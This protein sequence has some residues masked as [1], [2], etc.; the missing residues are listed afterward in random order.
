VYET[1]TGRRFTPLQNLPQARASFE[2]RNSPL[3]EN[4]AVAFEFGYNVQTPD[5]LVVWEAQYGDFINGAQL[6][7]DEFVLS[8]RAKWGQ[9]PSLVL[10]L[11]HGYEGQGPDH[12]SARPERF[13]QLAADINMRVASCTTA[14][15]YFHLLRRQAALLIEDPLPLVV[16]TPK[17]L[18]RHPFMSSTPRD[19]VEGRWQRVI[20]D[21][22]V[23]GAR[24]SEDVRRLILCGGKV[25]V[26]LLTSSTRA[27]TPAV[28]ICR[29]EQ[30]YPFPVRDL[31]TVMEGYPALEEVVWVQEEPENMGAWDFVRPLLEG[32]VGS[33]RLAVLA[34]PRSSS[35]AEGSAA[36][37]AQNQERLIYKAYEVA[38]LQK[39]SLR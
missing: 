11:P 3:S 21:P 32:L 37:H 25:G 36:R 23:S 8:A 35:P 39:A 1:N 27:T 2:V 17:S 34:R 6:V 31:T 5:R 33:R 16:L 19:L 22:D 14:A 9:E 20:D 28:A 12:A 38:S 10:L 4:A 29:V 26:D 7:L 15:Q 24:R 13:L 18:L 30:I